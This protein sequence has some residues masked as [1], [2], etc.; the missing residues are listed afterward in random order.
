MTDREHNV[1]ADDSLDRLLR[2]REML[3]DE[4]RVARRAS[5]ITAELVA[6]QFAKA[7]EILHR[8]EGK[9]SEEKELRRQL[10]DKLAEAEERERE[11]QRERRTLQ[12]M[13][14]ASVNMMEDIAA[15]REAAEAATRAKSEFLANMSHEIRTP[16]NGVIGMAGL[17]LETEL[18]TEQREYAETVRNSAEALL[19]IIN[20]ILDFSKVEAGRLVLETLDFN[21]I[22]TVEEATD[23]LAMRAEEKGLELVARIDPETP[24]HLRGD[25]GRLRQILINLI[26]NAIK[27]T[28]RGEV[29][30]RVRPEEG[31]RRRATLLFQIRDTG[32]GIPEEKIGK[33]FRSFSQTDAS[34][35]RR[36]GGTGLGLA[37]SKRLAELMGGKVGVE[38]APGKGSTFWFTIHLERGRE[39][40]A[41][42]ARAPV[43]G[44]RILLIED[45]EE[46]RADVAAQI[47]AAGHRVDEA[48]GGEEGAALFAEA[49]RHGDPYELVLLDATLPDLSEAQAV[50]ALRRADPDRVAPILLL[51]TIGRRRR[52]ESIETIG[53]DGCLTKPLKRS[54]L[55]E[56]LDAAFRSREDGGSGEDTG[57]GA[58][59]RIRPAPGTRVLV[60]EDNPV[61][62]KVALLLLKKMGCRADAVANGA[63]AV[64]ALETIPYDLVL[65]DCQM[66]EMDGFE[67]TRVI[68][69]AGRTGG[70]RPIPIVAMTAN[71]MQGDRDLCL[72]AGMDDYVA[73]PVTPKALEEVLCKWLPETTPVRA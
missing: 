39:G 66:P 32:I 12:E 10:T 48:A 16:M 33:L 53:A 7:D 5:D 8:L 17:L 59:E 41:S 19:T 44:R 46:C 14:I 2:D 11:L 72:D 45:N 61:N 28:D 47:R 63:E 56:A 69:E 38:S 24:K 34:T 54:T 22:E 55:H 65:M 13:Q 62:Q 52:G 21:L 6:E 35:T 3:R 27:F 58:P 29:V 25:P 36:Y 43:S 50:A 1:P 64:R 68:R 20:D 67:A 30:L 9:A 51:S 60:A 73:K 31:D 49:S 70:G 40:A 18:T 42:P 37:I 71:A 26:G 4:L 15:A 23:L 57:G